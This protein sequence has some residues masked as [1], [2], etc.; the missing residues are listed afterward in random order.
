MMRKLD[1]ESRDAMHRIGLIAGVDL[2]N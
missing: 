1:R 2:K